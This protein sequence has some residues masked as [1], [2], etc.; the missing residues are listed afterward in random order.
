[1]FKNIFIIF[2]SALRH[3][4]S[5]MMLFKSCVTL[6]TNIALQWFNCQNCK[7]RNL[8][9]SSTSCKLGMFVAEK[10]MYISES[11]F[12]LNYMSWKDFKTNAPTVKYLGMFLLFKEAETM[13]HIF[14]YRGTESE[15]QKRLS[16]SRQANIWRRYTKEKE[17]QRR[18]RH[19]A[20]VLVTLA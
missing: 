16:W 10:C 11:V 6:C 7:H 15:R 2:K 5:N 9:L 3:I 20:T 8:A 12:A 18:V 1:M 13:Q 19:P 17:T 14:F 4:W